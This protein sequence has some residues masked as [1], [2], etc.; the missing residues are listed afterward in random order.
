MKR[1]VTPQLKH[2]KPYLPREPQ[3]KIPKFI[4]IKTFT[5]DDQGYYTMA[6][7]ANVKTKDIIYNK[8]WTDNNDYENDGCH[9]QPGYIVNNTNPNYATEMSNYRLAMHFYNR[10]NDKYKKEMLS[11]PKRRAAYD[12]KMTIYN[13]WFDQDRIIRLEKTLNK[14]K[15]KQM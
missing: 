13:K 9:F 7:P 15:A 5:Y 11:Y 10:Q 4:P 12:K 3:A 8:V 1:P 14:L 6:L 2:G